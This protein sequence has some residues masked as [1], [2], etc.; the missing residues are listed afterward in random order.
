M[1]DVTPQAIEESTDLDALLVAVDK[2]GAELDALGRRLEPV[3][4][5][6]AFETPETPVA[7]DEM[8]PNA[9]KIFRARVAAETLVAHVKHYIGDIDL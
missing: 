7:R 6:N 4:I 3:R 2:L 8:S 9:R 5:G 1:E